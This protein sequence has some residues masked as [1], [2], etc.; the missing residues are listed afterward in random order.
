MSTQETLRV[1]GRQRPRG[2]KHAAYR[3]VPQSGHDLKP[4]R[5]HLL[6]KGLLRNLVYATTTE[7]GPKMSS[8]SLIMVLGKK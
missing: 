5:V 1:R 2:G 3:R 7:L 6:D 8:F 4:Q